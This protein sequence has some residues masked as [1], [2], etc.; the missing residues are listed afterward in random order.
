[1]FVRLV[2]DSDDGFQSNVC[3]GEVDVVLGHPELSDERWFMQDWEPWMIECKPGVYHF[4][5]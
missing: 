1:M 4:R 5:Y 2:Y 3:N